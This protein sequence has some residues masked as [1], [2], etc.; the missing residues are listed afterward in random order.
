LP[1][2]EICRGGAGGAKGEEVLRPDATKPILPSSATTR[3][4]GGWRIHPLPLN[5][6]MPRG[7]SFLPHPEKLAAGNSEIIKGD[8]NFGKK[9]R[10]QPMR[11]GKVKVSRKAGIS[12]GGIFYSALLNG[13]STAS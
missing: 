5:F 4:P 12:G 6:V 13:W 3:K 2:F 7:S 11:E 8:A 9:T 1:T 10:A